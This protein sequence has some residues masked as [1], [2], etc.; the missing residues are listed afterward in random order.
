[1]GGWGGGWVKEEICQS[2]GLLSGGFAGGGD[3]D[4]MTQTSSHRSTHSIT[5]LLFPSRL[6]PPPHLFDV[7]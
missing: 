5:Q 1:M 4:E 7:S 2:A 6:I 3:E